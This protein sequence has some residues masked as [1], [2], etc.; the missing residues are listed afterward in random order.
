MGE[1]RYD[2]LRVVD[3]L[4]GQVRFRV[5]VP[6]SATPPAERPVYRIKD[7]GSDGQKSTAAGVSHP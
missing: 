3:A 6:E 2:G 4:S 1:E 7:G 5:V